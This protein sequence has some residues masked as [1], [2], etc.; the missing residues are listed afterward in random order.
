LAIKFR[1]RLLLPVII[2]S[3][4][5]AGCT[6]LKNAKDKTTTPSVTDS[7]PETVDTTTK[8]QETNTNPTEAAE[9][10]N[11]PSANDSY[12][13]PDSQAKKLDEAAVKS[14]KPELLPF[15]RNEIY[16]RKGYVF[17]KDEYK[18]YFATKS[19]YKPNPNFKEG[20]LSDIEKYNVDLIKGYEAPSS[21][22]PGATASLMNTY[23][24][25]VTVS[26]D[27]NSDGVKEKITYKP[28]KSQLLI[29]SKAI[30][31][32]FDAPAKSFAIADIDTKDKFKEV[33]LSDYGPSSDYRTEYYYWDGSNI[34]KMGETEDMFESG[35]GINGSGRIIAETRGKILQTWFF[36]KTFKLSSQ[37]KVTEVLQDLYTTN[38]DVSLKMQLKLYK[39]KGD[40]SPSI[41]VNKGEKIKIIGTD[42]KAWCLLK[43]ASG[44]QGWIAVYNNS[45]IRNNGLEASDVFE[46]LCYAD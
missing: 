5:G 39:N 44:T 9:S 34:I 17:T 30:T 29:N 18:N 3:L 6:T 37:H 36:N 33:L 24:A 31:F 4:L 38:S 8:P 10:N 20:D 13:L 32:N 12:I 1:T 22:K 28:D 11:E 41:V 19:W 43:T 15:A 16:A 45:T 35:L 46:G 2:L 25:E 7:V 42:D 23:K 27:L 14:L 21:S 26:V 40:A